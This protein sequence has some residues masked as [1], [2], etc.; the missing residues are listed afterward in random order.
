MTRTAQRTNEVMKVLTL[1]SAVLLPSS[2]IAGV[3]GM[4]FDQSF[5]DQSWLF[6][7]TVGFM[8]LLMVTALGLARWR[9]WI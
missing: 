7:V 1:I 8:G 2:V 4:N 9:R 6:W 5:F 3:L